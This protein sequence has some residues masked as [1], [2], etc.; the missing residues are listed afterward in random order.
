MRCCTRSHLD[1]R[2][3]LGFCGAHGHSGSRGNRCT[4]L[5][6]NGQY[7]VAHRGRQHT[8]HSLQKWIRHFISVNTKK[9]QGG[10]HIHLQCLS[11]YLSVFFSILSW[12]MKHSVR[13]KYNKVKWV[14]LVKDQQPYGTWWERIPKWSQIHKTDIQNISPTFRNALAQHKLEALATF[15]SVKY[16]M[17]IRRQIQ[18]TS[19]TQ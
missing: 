9:T 5:D 1:S 4:P 19:N 17:D 6:Q 2:A 10:S 13:L 8:H 18:N 15:P 7:T 16:Q 3:S 14:S 11:V 12:V